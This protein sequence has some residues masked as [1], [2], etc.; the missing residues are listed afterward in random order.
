MMIVK[1]SAKRKQDKSVIKFTGDILADGD[2]REQYH[3]DISSIE[4]RKAECFQPDLCDVYDQG[5]RTGVVTSRP[6]SKPKRE[7]KRAPVLRYVPDS[8]DGCS[9]TFGWCDKL[10]AQPSGLYDAVLYR[11]KQP[12]GRFRLQLRSAVLAGADTTTV[13]H[14]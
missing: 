7:P 4:C 12:C 3:L 5:P 14:C 6:C 8:I 9:M 11:D 10:W 13:K 2:T 1:V